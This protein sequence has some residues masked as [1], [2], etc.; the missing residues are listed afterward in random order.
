MLLLPRLLLLLLLLLECRCNYSWCY[1]DL[2]DERD[3][4]H[5]DDGD[6]IPLLYHFQYMK[7]RIDTPSPLMAV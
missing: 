1:N 3:D 4:Q 2:D 6:H 5:D 7:R